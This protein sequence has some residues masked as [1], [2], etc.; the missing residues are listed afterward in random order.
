MWGCMCLCVGVYV[1]V[2][3]GVCVCG[4]VGVCVCLG[5]CDLW[6]CGRDSCRQ[7]ALFCVFLFSG[8]DQVA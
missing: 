5:V 2:G 4:C 8:S 7:L 1:F 3:G 6:M